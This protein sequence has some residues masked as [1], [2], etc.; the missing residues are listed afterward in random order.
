ME[1]D[2]PGVAVE[3]LKK[4]LHDQPLAAKNLDIYYTLAVASEQ[5]GSYE[6]AAEKLKAGSAL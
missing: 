3:K 6:K 4:A 2:L 5:M 1:R